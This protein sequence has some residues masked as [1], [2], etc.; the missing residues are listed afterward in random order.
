MHRLRLR[1][2][3]AVLIWP[4]IAWLG[5]CDQADAPLGFTPE[6]GLGTGT[7]P[8]KVTGGG[9]IDIVDATTGAT[10]GKAT[11]GFNARRDTD[12]AVRGH[13]NYLNHVSGV[14]LNCEVETG[15]LFT[16]PPGKDGAANF[17]GYECT[18]NSTFSNFRFTVV[19]AGEPG[20]D[21]EFTIQYVTDD[22]CTPIE[23]CT[24]SDGVVGVPIRSGNIQIHKNP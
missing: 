1:R 18:P 24:I 10:I 19:D 12:G 23:D 5:A 11:F 22:D 6:F 4:A 15:G 14:H 3:A 9:Q 13:I 2:T 7:L 8:G 20:R 16:P 21:D 17:G